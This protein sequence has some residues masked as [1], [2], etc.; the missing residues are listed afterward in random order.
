MTTEAAAPPAPAPEPAPSPSPAPEPQGVTR[1]EYI[2]EQFWDPQANAVKPEFGQHYSE[3]STFKQTYDQQQ[4]ALK[5]RKP[6]DIKIEVKPPEGFKL[7]DGIELKI[8]EKDPRIPIIRD[9]ALKRGLDQDTVNDLVWLDAQMQIEAHN[10]ERERVKAEDAKLGANG[11]D[12]KAAVT[13]WITNFKDLKPE[14]KQ[15]IEV[16]TAT[17]AG[18]ELVEMLMARASGSVPGAGGEP[19]RQPVPPLTIE[20][21]WY[22]GQKG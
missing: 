3:L 4:E 10:A 12:R 14:H 9:L 5:A 1:P 22:G 6:E 2:P 11:K 20:Q 17:A 19:P 8:D 18:V 21:R 15:E 16:L 7:P 13:N